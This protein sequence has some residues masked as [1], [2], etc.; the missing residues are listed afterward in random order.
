[1]GKTWHFIFV[2]VDTLGQNFFIQQENKNKTQNKLLSFKS[3]KNKTEK[4]N[5]T[6]LPPVKGF[7]Y[8]HIARIYTFLFQDGQVS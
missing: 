2:T 3:N 5:T 1:M 7:I 8:G 6:G 4:V